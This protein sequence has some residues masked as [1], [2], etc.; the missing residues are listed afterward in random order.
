[1]K[2]YHVFLP[3]GEGESI[4]DKYYRFVANW[5]DAK[6]EK[7]LRVQDIHFGDHSDLYVK[8]KD[9]EASMPVFRYRPIELVKDN[10]IRCKFDFQPV[11]FR[12]LETPHSRMT[13]IGLAI[14]KYLDPITI[15][16]AQLKVLINGKA[17]GF[18]IHFS[19]D[20]EKWYPLWEN[21]LPYRM[22]PFETLYVRIATESGEPISSASL[23]FEAILETHGF[24]GTGE[25]VV[26]PVSKATGEHAKAVDCPLAFRDDQGDLIL[27]IDNDMDEQLKTGSW[28]SH[29][30][31]FRPKFQG[32]P[33]GGG[34]MGDGVIA[35]PIIPA[36]CLGIFKMAIPKDEP[37]EHYFMFG[38][39]GLDF[40]FTFDLPETDHSGPNPWPGFSSGMIEWDTDRE[41]DPGKLGSKDTAPIIFDDGL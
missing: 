16:T 31:S 5:G 9:A 27:F 29:G 1:M 12:L 37:G 33:L 10:V 38:F 19:R 35:G 6:P 7:P 25:T 21:Y 26:A 2:G 18:N 15:V 14:P 41:Y 36:K 34:Y 39:G 3:L 23:D 8:E 20:G 30:S 40:H 11:R 17:D 4:D 24:R 32:G 22:L 13:D 28:F